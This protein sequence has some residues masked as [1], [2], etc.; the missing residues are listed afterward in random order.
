MFKMLIFELKLPKFEEKKKPFLVS[1]YNFV[2]K[3]K[4]SKTQ[5][6]KKWK[7]KANFREIPAK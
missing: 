4:I 5:K 7:W 1:T 6:K 2:P 3:R